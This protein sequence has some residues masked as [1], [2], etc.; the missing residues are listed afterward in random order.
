M[1]WFACPLRRLLAMDWSLRDTFSRPLFGLKPWRYRTNLHQLTGG[2]QFP[3]N[4]KKKKKRGQDNSFIANKVWPVGEVLQSYHDGAT[5]V[6]V[7]MLLSLIGWISDT[8]SQGYTYLQSLVKCLDHRDTA[9]DMVCSQAVSRCCF[10]QMAP[11]VSVC[12]WCI[13]CISM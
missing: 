13:A 12:S 4:K 1:R 3:C 10:G 8:L 6:S 5:M 2:G 9:S 11:L 7:Q